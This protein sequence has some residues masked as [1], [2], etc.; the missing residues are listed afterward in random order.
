M[1]LAGFSTYWRLWAAEEAVLS[2]A[3]PATEVELRM[4]SLRGANDFEWWPLG[5]VTLTFA[6]MAYGLFFNMSCT[7]LLCPVA[8]T[9]V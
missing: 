6:L 3:T 1:F 2:V 7:R 8:R 5:L 4:L 9:A